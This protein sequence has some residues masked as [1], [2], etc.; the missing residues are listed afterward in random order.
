M[1]DRT[2][3]W[4][5][6]AAGGRLAFGDPGTPGPR[7]AVVDSREAGEGD[8][9]VGL[10]GANVDGGNYGGQALAAGAWG[11]LVSEDAA[12]RIDLGPFDPHIEDKKGPG[13]RRPLRAPLY[14]PPAA[15]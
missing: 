14:C 10:R 11:V 4:V 15:V 2:A 8:L 7:R 12:A 5:A 6:G 1:I 13:P 3:E 9:F